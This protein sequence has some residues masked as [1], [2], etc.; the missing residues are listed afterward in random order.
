MRVGLRYKC[1]GINRLRYGNAVGA[2]YAT[3]RRSSGKRYGISSG[4]I[5]GVL[6]VLVGRCVA[7]AKAP[8]SL[9]CSCTLVNKIKEELGD[10]MLCQQIII[11]GGIKDFLDGYYL[12]NKVNCNAIYGQA[13]GFLK[14]AQGD[15]ET[16]YQHV[17]RQIEGLKLAQAYLTLK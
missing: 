14:H 15:Y 4:S 17:E 11:S 5:V 7:I 1:A 6:R 13:S 9:S 8:T 10:K 12:I 3:T 2:V 16:L